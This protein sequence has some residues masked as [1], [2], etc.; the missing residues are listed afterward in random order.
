MAR[1]DALN[2]RGPRKFVSDAV[3][4]LELHALPMIRQWY[5]IVLGSVMLPIPMFYV[6]QAIAPDDPAIWQRL[7]AGTLIF[8]VAFSTAMLVGQQIV[9]QRFLGHLRL[10]I[11][12]PVSKSAYV[13]GTLAFTSVAGVLSTAVL[14]GVRV[15][16]RRRDQPHVD[17]G[18]R[19]AADGAG[20]GRHRAVRH[21]LRALATGGK[22]HRQPGCH[23]AGDHL[24]GVFHHGGGA[25][26]CCAGSDTSRRCATP[27]MRSPHR[28]EAESMSDLSWASSRPT[29]SPL[30]AS[31]SGGCPG[32]RH[33][34]SAPHLSRRAR[35][36]DVAE[37][38]D[39]HSTRVARQIGER[40]VLDFDDIQ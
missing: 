12:M 20:A 4:V 14:A 36:D 35:L 25:L 9:A 28:S 40:Q 21:E 18:P 39:A 2:T 5:L 30:W 22:P 29:R 26:C 19:P 24:A 37:N 16:R 13:A 32:V 23:R 15:C 10:I 38:F 34:A 6:F 11:T 17:A 8:G 1:A 27:R 3:A 31:A 7:L 33:R